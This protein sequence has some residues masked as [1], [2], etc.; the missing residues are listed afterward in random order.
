M[1]GIPSDLKQLL[2]AYEKRIIELENQLKALDKK[3]DSLP[4]AT[5]TKGRKADG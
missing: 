2:I 4:K 3:I 5:P 1:M